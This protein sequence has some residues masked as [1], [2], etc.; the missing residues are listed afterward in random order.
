MVDT[1]SGSNA[2]VASPPSKPRMLLMGS[3]RAGKSSIQKVV[4][5]KM[6]PHE[7]LFIVSTQLTRPQQ[8]RARQQQRQW[9]LQR[10]QFWRLATPQNRTH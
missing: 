2:M 4:F 6:S 7:T 8:Q 9:L 10:Q 3:R 1:A 5:H